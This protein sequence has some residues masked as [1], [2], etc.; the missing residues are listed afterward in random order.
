MFI[1]VLALDKC[2][3]TKLASNYLVSG[4][5]V[6][7][8]KFGFITAMAS[9]FLNNIPMN[10]LFEKIATSTPALYGAVI[11]S[12]VGAFI[13]PVGALAGIMWNKILVKHGAKVSFFKFTVCGLAVAIPTLIASTFILSILI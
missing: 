13:T 6:D 5:N 1:I 2:G 11:G 8:V 9:N 10:V 4:T 3:F 7:G 12:N